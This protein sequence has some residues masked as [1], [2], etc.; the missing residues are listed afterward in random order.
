MRVR[1]PQDG[2]IWVPSLDHAFANGLAFKSLLAEGPNLN[3]IGMRSEWECGAPALDVPLRPP[4]CAINAATR[5]LPVVAPPVVALPA[6]AWPVIAPPVIAWRPIA[7]RLDRSLSRAGA[8]IATACSAGAAR[9]TRIIGAAAPVL[10]EHIAAMRRRAHAIGGAARYAAS[11][12]LVASALAA[13]AVAIVAWFLV[14]FD[15]PVA[16]RPDAAS[17]RDDATAPA[18]MPQPIGAA[19]AATEPT[20]GS[21]HLAAR[22]KPQLPWPSLAVRLKPAASETTEDDAAASAVVIGPPDERQTPQRRSDPRTADSV[23][24]QMMFGAGQQRLSRQPSHP[25]A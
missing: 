23:I 14:P 24:R 18:M 8:R 16:Y 12:R 22:L 5:Q 20:P 25:S 3:A 1:A 21:D 10:H 17:A 6:I 13:I 15:Q 4:S 11:D 2:N 9:G 7:A 19:S